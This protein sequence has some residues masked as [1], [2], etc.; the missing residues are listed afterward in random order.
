MSLKHSACHTFRASGHL[1][2][3]P[4]RDSFR[5]V[6]SMFF[7]SLCRVKKL[8]KHGRHARMSY[9]GKC[10]YL[11][12]LL[13]HN[14]KSMA[15]A[16]LEGYLRVQKNMFFRCFLGT[17]FLHFL[18]I[19]VIHTTPKKA[20]FLAHFWEPFGS[21]RAAFGRLFVTKMPQRLQKVTPKRPNG[22]KAPQKGSEKT[23]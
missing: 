14:A 15:G 3:A 12:S 17:V 23:T 5:S 10:F 13:S 16:T 11:L 20:P 22:S 9:G 19:R 8:Q 2:W 18:E 1:R 6:F 4:F 21:L 7:S